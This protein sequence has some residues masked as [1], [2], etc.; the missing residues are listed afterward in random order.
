MQQSHLTGA[1]NTVYAMDG[2]APFTPQ[3]L[4][5]QPEERPMTD[6]YPWMK[7]L[8][9]VPFGPRQNGMLVA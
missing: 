4:K 1:S 8:R 9:T 2:L 3:R 5:T 6:A 7:P